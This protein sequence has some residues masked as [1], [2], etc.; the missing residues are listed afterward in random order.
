MECCDLV[1]GNE[2]DWKDINRSRQGRWWHGRI[3]EDLGPGTINGIRG[4]RYLV[5]W[6]L[7][8]LWSPFVSYPKNQRV[9]PSH[10]EFAE[11]K[12]CGELKSCVGNSSLHPANVRPP[13]IGGRE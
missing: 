5:R 7:G 6:T 4:H 3:L 13:E 11:V 1:V 9:T 10:G 12:F 8:T 2:V